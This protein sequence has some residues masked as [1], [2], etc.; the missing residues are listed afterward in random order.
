MSGSAISSTQWDH[1]W[2][3]TLQTMYAAVV[4]N[5]Q[6]MMRTKSCILY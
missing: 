4:V 5:S 3:S 6:T 1:L 2:E